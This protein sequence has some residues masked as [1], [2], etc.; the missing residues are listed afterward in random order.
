VLQ[1]LPGRHLE[2]L[3]AIM[4]SMG[5]MLTGDVDRRRHCKG[6]LMIGRSLQQHRCSHHACTTAGYIQKAP[7]GMAFVTVA[8]CMQCKNTV[9]KKCQLGDDALNSTRSYD[10]YTNRVE[11]KDRDFWTCTMSMIPITP[12]PILR[13]PVFV[14]SPAIPNQPFRKPK[15]HLIS[16]TSRLT[17]KIRRCS[18][19]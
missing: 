12:R 4:H 13:A 14:Y 7:H 1:E 6:L 8:C 17:P 18:P 15:P 5:A 9:L 2:G 3:Q 11:S 16:F 10:A 19:G